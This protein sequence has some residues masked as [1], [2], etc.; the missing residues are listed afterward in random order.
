MT[1]KGFELTKDESLNLYFK[2][3]LTRKMEEKDQEMYQE[4]LVSV[5]AHMDTGQEAAVCGVLGLIC[6]KQERS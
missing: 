6:L 4:Q 5:Y 2:I 3:V 1:V